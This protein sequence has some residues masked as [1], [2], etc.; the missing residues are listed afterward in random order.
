LINVPGGRG[1]RSQASGRSLAADVVK[2]N[3]MT[4]GN[5]FAAPVR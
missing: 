2:E 3:E 1:G 5:N 4:L